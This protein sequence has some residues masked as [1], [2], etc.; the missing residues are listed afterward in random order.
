MSNKFNTENYQS[1][2]SKAYN[3]N[4]SKEDVKALLEYFL[5]LKSIKEGRVSSEI[6]NVIQHLTNTDKS[7]I[8]ISENHTNNTQNT[9]NND[10]RSKIVKWVGLFVLA[11]LTPLAVNIVTHIIIPPKNDDAPRYIPLQ[12]Q[13]EL[14]QQIT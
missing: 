8:H 2:I 5:E 10:T 13:T 14:K 9:T 1:Q 7:N 4:N 12:E 3:P 6:E 11:F